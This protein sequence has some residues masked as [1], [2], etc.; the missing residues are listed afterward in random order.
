MFLSLGLYSD[1][2]VYFSLP[3]ADSVAQEFNLAFEVTV[4]FLE[5]TFI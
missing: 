4:F 5:V 1:E 2:N 3:W